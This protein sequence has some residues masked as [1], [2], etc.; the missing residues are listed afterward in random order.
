MDMAILFQ[1]WSDGK[2][3]IF[4]VV[5]DLAM[6][7]IHGW[8]HFGSTSLAS[9]PHCKTF[10]DIEFYQPGLLPLGNHVK[11]CLEEVDVVLVSKMS[12]QNTVVCN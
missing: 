6:E 12:K 2:S 4:S 7:S 8:I 10:T 11:I 5:C 1:I 3:Q 9:N